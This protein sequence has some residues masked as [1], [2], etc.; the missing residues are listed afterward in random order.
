[1][2]TQLALLEMPQAEINQDA[3]GR[4]FSEFCLYVF[5]SRLEAA[6]AALEHRISETANEYFGKDSDRFNTWDAMIDSGRSYLV[7]GSVSMAVF[8]R[9]HTSNLSPWQTLTYEW[10]LAHPERK[11]ILETQNRRLY[12]TIYKRGEFVE[13]GLPHHGAGGEKHWVTRDGK[14]KVLINVD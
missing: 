12:Y 2:S 8:L 1:M 9:D 10:C 4:T 3:V 5:N 6:A 13:I 11:I 14:K 7:G